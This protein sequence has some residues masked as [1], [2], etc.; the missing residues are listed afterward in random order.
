VIVG[1]DT[2]A[3]GKALACLDAGAEVTVVAR[4]VVD[5][6]ARYA[7]DGRLRHVARDYH[8]GDL[9]GAVLCHA[10]TGDSDLVA[11]L[12]VDATRA[13]VLLNVLD[14][15]AACGFLAPAVVRRGDLLIAVGTGGA[16]P[17]LS[18][19]LRR[20]I[21]AGVGREYEPYVAILGAVRRA[22]ADDPQR[23]DVVTTL[24]DS[25]LLDLLRAGD[26]AR[27]DALLQDV[28]GEGCTLARL[29]VSLDEGA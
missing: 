12:R 10:S 11:R 22:M 29:G 25:P 18:A 2:Q 23:K 15:P 6:V 27:V 8:T 24:L 28:A 14:T 20:E 21:E 3:A 9:A 1:G 13:H 26:A 4:E 17:G 19:R 16:S 7:A 5:A